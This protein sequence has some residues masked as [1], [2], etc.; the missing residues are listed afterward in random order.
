[1][2]VTYTEIE[3]LRLMAAKS[4]ENQARKWLKE[5]AAAFL[6]NHFNGAQGAADASQVLK[7]LTAVW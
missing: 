2:A 4:P 6:E 5:Q 7:N 1:M 3:Q